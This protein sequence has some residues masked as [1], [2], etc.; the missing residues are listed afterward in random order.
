MC[1]IIG[2]I[3]LDIGN[4]TWKNVAP[5]LKVRVTFER[6]RIKAIKESETFVLLLIDN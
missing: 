2:Y 1:V 6:N 3:K 5:C 4:I